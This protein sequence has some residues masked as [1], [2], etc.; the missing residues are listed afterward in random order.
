[1]YC[2][3]NLTE[4]ELVNVTFH[5]VVQGLSPKMACFASTLTHLYIYNT[6]IFYLPKWISQFKRLETIKLSNTGL[7]YLS[8]SIGDLLLLKF[9]ILPDNN[10]SSIPRTLVNL[11]SLQELILTN[12]RYLRSIQT[13]NGHPSL[14]FLDT[15]NCPIELLPRDLFRITILKMTNNN[16][17]NLLGIDTLGKGISAEK[18]FEFDQNH[19]QTVSPK[20]R[21]VRNL[22][23]L[24]LAN[25]NLTTL[26]TDIFDVDTL[27]HLNIEKNHF[28]NR[29]LQIIITKFHEINPDLIILHDLIKI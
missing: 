29:Q 28:P 24:N 18:H 10:L 20:I 21:D 2:L 15:R 3:K 16:L 4:L 25:N 9:L 23:Q 11:R 26:P 6:K 17:T 22:K 1:M 12:N 7:R 27:G 19:I 8:D 5:D 14:R 13:L